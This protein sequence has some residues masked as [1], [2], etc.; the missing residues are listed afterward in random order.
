MRGCWESII[1]Y[2]IFSCN[3]I[4]ALIG[5]G[6]IGLGTYIQVR[7]TH[8][9]DFLSASYLTTPVI[10]ILIG[11][12]IFVIA[13]FA[14]CGACSESSCMVYTYSVL[15]GLV[16]LAQ[17][18]AGVAALLLR[19]DLSHTIQ[20][21][22]EESLTNY[23]SGPE[24]GG[25]TESWN[26]VQQELHC[27]GANNR[28]D[29]AELPVFSNGSLPSS[30]CQTKVGIGCDKGN[31]YTSGCFDLV[32]ELFMSHIGIIGATVLTVASLEVVTVLLACCLGERINRSHLYQQF[33]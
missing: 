30:C 22:M 31:A 23:G 16:L 32:T 27:C 25:V 21:N 29:W 26:F 13:T 9:L 33:H 5:V 28:T 7:A 14:C 6:F 12:V 2:F 4:F 11:V 1:K 20:S 17:V 24:F 18:G 19:G 15:L 10:V 8:Y 3:L